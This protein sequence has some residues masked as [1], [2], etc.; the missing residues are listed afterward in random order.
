MKRIYLATMLAAMLFLL[1][2][3]FI[4]PD[5]TLDPLVIHEGVVPFGTVQPLPTNT[6]TPVAEN[7]PTPT[8]DA[9][10]SSDQS[11]WED[12]AQGSL[13]TSTP[14]T[15]ATAAPGAQSWAT[16]TEDYNAGYPV[17]MMGSTGTD[18]SDLQ[19]RLTEL[20]YYTGAIDGRYASG[21]Q[22][23]VQEFQERNGLTADGIAGRQTQDLLYSGSAQPK[24][25]TVSASGD[26]EEY[27]LLKQ[28]TSG[29]EVRKLQ[30]RLAELG[31]YAG[32]VD[33]IYGETTASAVK[34]FQRA[35]GLSGDG[36]AG[37]QTQ[38]KLY[39]SS[40][41]YASSPV[42]T[43]NPDATRTLTLGMT[44]NDVYA[45]Q[46][47]LIEL[48]YLS[49]VADG[50]FG[51]ETQAA[52]IAFQKNNGL[53]ADG[54]AGSSTL[55]KLAGSCKAATRTTPTPAPAGTVTLREGD[56]GENVYILQAYLFEL[57]YY[58]GRIDG[59][60]SAETTEAVKAF[61][62]ANGL[63]ADGIAGKGTQSKLTSGSAIPAGNANE[64][65]QESGTPPQTSELTT[66]RRGDKSAQVMVMQQ[67]LMELGYL[68]TQPDGQF[69]AG[70]ERAVKL[71]Q[72]A[73]GLTADGVAGKG[74]L[75]IL[76]SGSAVAYGGSSGGSSSSGSSPAA[77]ATPRPNT[78]IV[79]Q[80]ESEGDD[81]RQ[82][83]Q[84]LV[85]L[86]Y[87]SSK[88]V[89]G[90]FNQPTVEATK[91][92]QTM[93]GL[94]VDGAAGPQSLKLIYSNDALNADGV[95]VGDLLMSSSG[96]G[97]SE[98]LTA[99][100][101]GEQVRQVQSR[102]AELGY[103]SASFVNGVYDDNTRQA[104]RRFQQANGLTADGAAGSATQSRL[105]AS[106]AVTAQTARMAGD[107]TGR[108]TQEY[109]VNGAYQL[110][111]GGGGI[112]VGDR[113]ALYCADASQGGAL[114]KRPYDGSA[115]T[116]LAYETPRFLHL[117]N[118]R[119]YYV[120]SSGGE[121]CVIRMNADGTSHEVLD[122]AGVI[123]RFALHDGVMYVLDANGALK[124]RTLS[125]EE[126]ELMEGVADFCLDV[127]GNALLCV[128]QEGVVSFGIDTGR[129]TTL[130][131]GSADQAVLCA[132]ILLV[133][134]GGSILR[135]ANGQTATIRRDGAKLMGV[136]G[137]K[138]ISLTGKGVMTC[139]VNGENATM[140]LYG[141]YETMSA[142]NGVLYV[143]DGKGVAQQVTL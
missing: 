15:A 104:I 66:L 102:L 85:E 77:T 7:Q 20:G 10:Q 94:K 75:S 21:T 117:T 106:G 58:T 51:A 47:R 48:R 86:G 56:E 82:Y 99:G 22:T 50:V 18:V 39:S 87:L 111:V 125:G 54:N 31:Y 138:V 81:V 49:G 25:V 60:F 29:V 103:L 69:G 131:A 100:M 26:A 46:E 88:Y 113:S 53:T 19:A 37:V 105:Y 80:W 11:T 101:T 64:N 78:D 1:S 112:A 74:T 40:A 27:L 90:K 72:E 67:Y 107:N 116:V 6:P 63:T 76:Y 142:A 12:W 136:Y 135:V 93:N 32:G 129:T 41:R 42:A 8:P 55:K 126:S 34:A 109:R 17:L 84:R 143:G 16:S 96:T 108:Q 110:S 68:S 132:D 134:S 52:L 130:Y 128:T 89:T 70:T 97:V 44:G 121:D 38:S 98:V 71:F 114:V 43:A 45:L 4:Q 123:L 92:F 36:Q 2:G 91:A 118:G 65:G 79:I 33:G 57:G 119:L 9:W 137:Q 62:R 30:G 139:D 73:N 124:E 3:C 122:R 5:P 133:R 141:A 23:A 61:Q 13:P 95:R 127:Q 24:Y 35:N 59:R 115:A 83:Q 120:A 140:I 14:R 28:G